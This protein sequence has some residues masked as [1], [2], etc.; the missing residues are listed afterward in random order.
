MHTR[1]VADGLLRKKGVHFGWTQVSQSP[2]QGNLQ[3]G[4]WAFVATR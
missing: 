3:A 2:G 4:N 1:K